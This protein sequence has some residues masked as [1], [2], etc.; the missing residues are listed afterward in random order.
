[1]SQL[2]FDDDL[3]NQ[4]ETLYRT[5]DVLRRRRLVRE[6]LGAAPGERV[7]DVGCGPGFYV[8]ELVSSR[9]GRPARWS[10]S[11]PARRPSRWP[12][13]APR[14]R[15]TSCCTRR[16]RPRCR[17]RTPAST[18]RC[19][20]RCS[21]TSPTRMPPLPSCTAPSAPAAGWSSG[22][23]TGRRCPGT[24]PIPTGCA[25]CWPFGTATWPTRACREPS[26]HGCVRR[27][28]ATSAPRATPS[29]ARS[30][31]SD[32]YGVAVLPLIQ[33]YVAG[34]DDISEEAAGEW[35]A[36]QHELGEQ[37]EFFFACIQ[38]CFT[39]TRSGCRHRFSCSTS[40]R[41]SRRRCAQRTDLP[42]HDDAP[43][44]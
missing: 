21:S 14:A 31:R 4:L 32:S 5:R 18:G 19:R 39:A 7:L 12:G 16:M 20:C 28:S 24:R 34:R 6:A 33:R 25:A 9:S 27:G 36:E 37:G 29:P 1:M 23:S 38:F 10:G 22:T 40:P 43:R 3:A 42:R 35:A 41:G 44:P 13:A 30:S 11:T 26:R 2:V 8:A 15:T 17:W